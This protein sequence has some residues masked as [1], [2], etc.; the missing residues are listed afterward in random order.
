MCY[1]L[2]PP[3][4]CS[5]SQDVTE[6]YPLSRIEQEVREQKDMFGSLDLHETYYKVCEKNVIHAVALISVIFPLY[7][8]CIGHTSSQ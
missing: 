6:V 4:C 5:H 7:L 1:S 3:P 8:I 2:V